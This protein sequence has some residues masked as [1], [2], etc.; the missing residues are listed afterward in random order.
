MV[1][2]A[3]WSISVQ[4][5]PFFFLTSLTTPSKMSCPSPSSPSPKC[6][7]LFCFHHGFHH[8]LKFYYFSAFAPTLTWRTL[9][10]GQLESCPCLHSFLLRLWPSGSQPWWHIRITWAALTNI[11]CGGAQ[12]PLVFFRPP[13]VILVHTRDWETLPP[14]NA[15]HIKGTE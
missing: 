4:M 7:K 12:A 9:A 15:W 2:R 13:Q 10:P 8:Y 6:N 11:I 1:W 14:E 5:S 3:F